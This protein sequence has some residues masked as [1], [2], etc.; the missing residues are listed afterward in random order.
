MDFSDEQIISK[1]LAGDEKSLEILIGR[2]IKPIYS[3]VYRYVGN[4]QEA[5]D[6]TQEVFVK[7]WRNLKGFNQNKIFK[8]WIFAIAKNA[9][10]DY[11]KKKKNIAFSGFKDKE[12][13]SLI[14]NIAD[15]ISLPDKIFRRM[16]I[17]RILDIA[18][19]ELSPKYRAVLFLR[20]ND[21]FTFKEIS[22]IL[23]LPI[24]TVKSQHRRALIRL[25]ELILS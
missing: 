1:Y 14:E 23:E 22:E 20:Y 12:G 6:I 13:N 2:H 3:F 8:T 21:H 5:E 7:M 19:S 17:G 9:S 4:I 11:L 24:H 18:T 10:I 16:E 25:R 15:P